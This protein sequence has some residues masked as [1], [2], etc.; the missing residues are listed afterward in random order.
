[1]DM[2]RIHV[3]ILRRLWSIPTLASLSREAWPKSEMLPSWTIGR[4]FAGLP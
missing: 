1:M 4:G 3:W 2:L